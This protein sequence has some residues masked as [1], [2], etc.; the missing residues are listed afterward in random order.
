M[1]KF[2]NTYLTYRKKSY[3]IIFKLKYTNEYKY[4][5][6]SDHKLSLSEYALTNSSYYKNYGPVKFWIT[7]D[8]DGYLNT[9]CHYTKTKVIKI[10]NLKYYYKFNF[11][12]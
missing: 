9:I 11:N 12:E 2:L 8:H 5:N 6:F 10:Y 4:Y 1:N 7:F 3:L